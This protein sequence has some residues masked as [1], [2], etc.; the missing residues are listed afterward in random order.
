M[1]CALN[2]QIILRGN[3]F[4]WAYDKPQVV[5]LSTLLLFFCQRDNN[6]NLEGNSYWLGQYYNDFCFFPQVRPVRRIAIRQDCFRGDQ[7][8]Y[9]RTS[10]TLA[11]PTNTFSFALPFP[12]RRL[13]LTL[14]FVS[15]HTTSW[16]TTFVSRREEEIES[17]FHPERLLGRDSLMFQQAVTNVLLSYIQI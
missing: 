5:C 16:M 8:N 13:D 17:E 2:F 7:F 9:T 15:D 1:R 6:S 10:I 11:S 14:I 12:P 4:F 3:D